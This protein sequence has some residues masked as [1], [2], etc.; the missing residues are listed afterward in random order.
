MA[1]RSVLL[2]PV[3]VA[4]PTL[5]DAQPII[6]SAVNSASYENSMIAPGSI[7]TVFG[8][9]IGPEQLQSAS[10]YPLPE[11]LA[12]T[13]I[14]VTAGSTVLNCPMIYASL[15]QSAAILPSNTPAGPAVIHVTY[16]GKTDP[17]G[18]T[19]TIQ[20]SAF[21]IYTVG[22]SG[23]GPGVITG[24]DYK[25]KDLENSAHPG[26]TLILWGT[27][28]G[29]ISGAD[30]IVPTTGQQFSNV[31]VYVGSQPAA[32]SYAGRSGCCA[33]LDQIAFQV[34]A[35]ISGCSVP[36]VLRS[37]D[38]ISNF[39]TLPIATSGSVCSDRAPAIPTSILTKTL[40]GAEVRLG[41]M[42]VGP[43]AILHGAGFQFAHAI[44]QQ[45]SV[46]LHG[47]VSD[48]DARRI[49]SSYQ[50]RDLKAIARILRSY[51]AP[52]QSPKQLAH[53]L[54][55]AISLDQQ[56]AAAAF[57]SSVGLSMLA[58]PFAS[59]LPPAGACIVTREPSVPDGI[60]TRFLDAGPSLNI[61][62]PLGQRT[63]SQMRGQYQISF[64]SGFSTGLV[65]PGVYTISGTGGR[66]IPAFSSSLTVS[67]AITWTNKA[68]STSIDR[69]QPLTV[70]WAG[71]SVPGYVM[72]GASVHTIN[73]NTT[74]ACTE[75]SAKGSFTIPAFALAALPAVSSRYAYMFV[76][77]HPLSNLVSLPGLDVAYFVNGSSDYQAVELR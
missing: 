6:F 47:D 29:P 40:S 58:L 22:S 46:V 41:A 62:G 75:D 23:L 55:S 38:A 59:H 18:T 34:P 65:P 42:A 31:E 63:M 35:S 37:G 5:I 8:F 9:G 11:R 36:V 28:L 48:D 54:R 60:H 12:G 52:K 33:G 32:V 76:A 25:V 17:S 4:A 13:S 19:V 30:N 61:N 39:V 16:N 24:V 57:G 3:L 44:A 53:M 72:I 49:I 68:A 45:L 10:T 2:I 70:T 56:G 74:L 50:V 43:M 51:Q 69:S 71:A 1:S 20:T 27:G 14:Q 15:K 64:G 21:G 66:D 26:E 77:P 7:F 67:N 73:E